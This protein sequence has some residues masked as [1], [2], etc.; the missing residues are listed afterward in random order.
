MFVKDATFRTMWQEFLALPKSDVP[1][2]G[3]LGEI[4]YRKLAEIFLMEEMMS[5]LETVAW[6][7]NNPNPV[8][9]R[10]YLCFQG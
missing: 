10:K 8:T 4:V 9:M 5:D 7:P 6:T 2:T 3:R 1:A